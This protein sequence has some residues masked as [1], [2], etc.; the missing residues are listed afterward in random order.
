MTKKSN[1]R[2]LVRIVS[3]KDDQRQGVNSPQ[4]A[5]G[6]VGKKELIDAR[7]V[8]EN[9]ALGLYVKHSSSA[10]Q[11]RPY[12]GTAVKIDPT[13]AH[14]LKGDPR[15]LRV[16]ITFEDGKKTD[17]LINMLESLDA[18]TRELLHN[19]AMRS[20]SKDAKSVTNIPIPPRPM[21]A[22]ARP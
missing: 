10:G 22:G 7:M 17:L 9:S 2:I 21:A 1:C 11:L 6:K 4:H 8:D 19:F 3:G 20:R 12:L 15:K 16:K 14:Y 5:R 13:T 18:A